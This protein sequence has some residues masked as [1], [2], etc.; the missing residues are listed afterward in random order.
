MI[1][2]HSELLLESP[3]IFTIASG[4]QRCNENVGRGETT[5]MN[6]AEKQNRYPITCDQLEILDPITMEERGRKTFKINLRCRNAL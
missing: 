4:H 5:N 3:T 2:G 6:R 1:D